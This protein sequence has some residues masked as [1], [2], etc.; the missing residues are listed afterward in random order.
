MKQTGASG[1]WNIQD[2]RYIKTALT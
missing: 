1:E 2:Q